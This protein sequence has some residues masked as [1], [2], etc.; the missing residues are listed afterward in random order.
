MPQTSR[1]C[2][3]TR[4]RELSKF[5]ANR[6]TDKFQPVLW[7]RSGCVRART[8][9]RPESCQCARLFILSCLQQSRSSRVS[10]SANDSVS[11]AGEEDELPEAVSDVEEAP[12]TKKKKKA[13]KS[14]RE[15]RSSKRQRPVREV[16]LMNFSVHCQLVDSG[17]KNFMRFYLSDLTW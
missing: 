3:L 6:R 7:W 12:K 14:S 9:T 16:R 2:P 17:N 5:F 13:K 10:S 4:G 11:P 8:D 15:S 1:V